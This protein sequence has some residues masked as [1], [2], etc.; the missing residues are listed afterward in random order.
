MRG[1]H[2]TFALQH[3][4][5]ISTLVWHFFLTS[6]NKSE[7][8]I[9]STATEKV[10]SCVRLRR[11][12]KQHSKFVFCFWDS[13]YV[14]FDFDLQR[15]LGVSLQKIISQAIIEFW[16]PHIS[17][18]GKVTDQQTSSPPWEWIM[19][20][21]EPKK[22]IKKNLSYSALLS[23][24]PLFVMQVW[25]GIRCLAR[26]TDQCFSLLFCWHKHTDF[27]C[28]LFMG[29]P[30]FPLQP[31]R[32]AHAF[33]VSHITIPPQSAISR[34]LKQQAVFNVGGVLDCTNIY[35]DII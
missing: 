6:L 13:L 20:C 33:N 35:P 26:H 2:L 17:A 27:C 32:C 30:L 11:R 29:L 28:L 15:T 21:C 10:S 5:K 18:P 16:R 4:Y 14:W 9:C 1:Q 12:I 23:P 25:M 8:I 19:F 24:W 22:I 3:L 34:I 7:L 31:G